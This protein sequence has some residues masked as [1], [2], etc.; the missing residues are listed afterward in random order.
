[1][2][3]Q[4]RTAVRTVRFLMGN[5]LIRERLSVDEHTNRPLRFYSLTKNGQ[6]I[7]EILDQAEKGLEAA[8]HAG[9]IPAE[10][11]G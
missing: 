9:I 5:A 4:P 8:R 7:A 6:Q 11:E 10:L 2:Y 3:L 1:M